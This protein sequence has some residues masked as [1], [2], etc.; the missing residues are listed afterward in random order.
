MTG[1][2]SVI[3]LISSQLEIEQDKISNDTT[4]DELGADSLDLIDVI[5]DIEREYDVEI[6]QAELD[7]IKTIGDIEKLLCERI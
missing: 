5:A 3:E 6:S 4:F 2:N 7:R 1:Y